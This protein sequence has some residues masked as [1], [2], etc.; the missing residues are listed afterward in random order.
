MRGLFTAGV[1]DYFLDEG[2]AFNHVIGVSAG[3]CHACSYLCGQRGRAY[4]TNTDYINNKEYCS[5]YSLR[6]TGD[7]FGAEFVYHRIPEELY[8]IDNDYFRQ[9][10]VHF[11]VAVTNC[12]TGKAEYPQIKDMFKD[13]EYVRASSSL[14][15]FANMVEME[16]QLYMDGGIADSIPIMQSVRQGNEKNVIILTQPRDYQKKP[17][18]SVALAALKYKQ[19]PN[20]VKALARRHRVYNDTLNYIKEL[21]ADGK[22]FV[23]APMG[24]L[25]IGRIEKDIRKMDKAYYEGYFVTEALSKKLR[26]FLDE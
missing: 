21:E 19:Y 2:F 6:K 23:I 17:T 9:S 7:L 20:L 1:I 22:A 15:F 10:D 8:P 5:Y 13:V 12:K 3:A 25:D 11:Q 26:A 14:P 16:G 18:K 24:P 4:A